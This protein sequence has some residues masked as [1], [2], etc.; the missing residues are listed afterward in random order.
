MSQSLEFKITAS[1]QASRV[2][3]EVQRKVLGFGKEIVRS[4]ISMVGP[5]AL[6]SMAFSK[7]SERMEDIKQK[8]KDAFDWGSDLSS[9]AAAMGVTVEEFQKF[10]DISSRTGQTI[11]NIGKAFKSAGN[12]I[13]DANAGNK[14]AIESL[15]ALGFTVA[16]LETLKP[17]DVVARLGDALA[18]IESPTDKAAAAFATFGAEGKALIQTLERI[19]GLAKGPAPEGLTQGEADFL[20]EAKREEEV[21]GNRERLQLARE[22]ATARFLKTDEGRKIIERESSGLPGPRTSVP[23]MPNIPQTDELAKQKRIQDEV[24]AIL[25]ERARA[26]VIPPTPAGIEAGINAARLGKERQEKPKPPVKEEVVKAATLTVSS[27]R[28]IGG[29]MAGE[30]SAAEEMAREA[31]EYA[32]RTAEALEQIANSGRP[33]T[34]FTKPVP[35]GLSSPT[36]RGGVVA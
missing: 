29:G 5:L 30:M 23:V 34:D 35:E 27:L 33:I 15:E 7:I 3:A 10:Q 11:E 9:T 21:A 28:S 13:A 36:G 12:L 22:A 16:D 24:Q 8:A 4:V 25:A 6:M 26:R 14:Q 2:V 17:E 1:D 19:R 18:S 31:L 32:R 20:A